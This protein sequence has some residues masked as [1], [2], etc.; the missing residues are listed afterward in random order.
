MFHVGHAQIQRP[1]P[2][3]VWF[4]TVSCAFTL[5]PANWDIA[6]AGGNG[7]GNSGSNGGQA[8]NAGNRGNPSSA[9]THGSVTRELK[10]LNAAHA[11][12]TGLANAAPNS[13]LG[14]LAEAMDA[15][16]AD[17]SDD[18]KDRLDSLLAPDRWSMPR[19]LRRRP[20]P[21]SHL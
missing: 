16:T 4:A 7:G 21:S 5:D 20:W 8:S 13:M 19:K 2:S 15:L 1:C 14:K 3:Q 10:G 11:N 17:L 9:P 6:Q 12:T 18:A